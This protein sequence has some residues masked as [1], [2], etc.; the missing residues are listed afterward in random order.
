MS[1]SSEFI[2]QLLFA[3]E[4]VSL[5]FKR[6][7]Y[8]FEDA[9]NEVKSELLKDILAFVNA[10]RRTDAYILIGVE[11]GRGG[12]SRVVGVQKHLEDANLQQFVNSKTQIPLT[13]SYLELTHDQLPIGVIHIPLQ[14]RPIYLTKKFGKVE[15]ETVYIRRG[16]S[17]GI[18]KPEEIKRMG[19]SSDGITNQPTVKLRLVDRDTGGYLP[20]LVKIPTPT[21]LELPPAEEI[22]DYFPRSEVESTKPRIDVLSPWTNMDYH[23]EVAEYL[24]SK[25]CFRASLELETTGTSVVHD[26]IVG[27]E[28]DD[29][30]R[31]YE[32]IASGDTPEVPQRETISALSFA[33]RTTVDR[34]VFV[35]KKGDTWKV[36]CDFGKIRPG[37]KVGLID[38][39]LIGSRTVGELHLHG[40]VFG[41]NIAIPISVSFGLHLLTGSRPLTVEEILNPSGIL[42]N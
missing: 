9:D 19:T 15:K 32:L 1:I 41:D 14:E 29:P 31:E 26:A 34:D 36:D 6:D 20:N 17:T 7:Q 37:S 3:D 28:L 5:D 42:K 35:E 4:D 11:E 12:R 16:S 21:W 38:D 27:I 39:L 10:F 13:F 18:A 2:E 22:P 8:P 40:K 24:Q 25:F 33:S 30:K 23:R